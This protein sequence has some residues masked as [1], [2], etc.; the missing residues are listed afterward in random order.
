MKEWV[1]LS[2]VIGS[3]SGSRRS[4]AALL[5]SSIT[6]RSAS[7]LYAFVVKRLPFEVALP[8]GSYR[9]GTGA[10]FVSPVAAEIGKSP[11]VPLLVA[12]HGRSTDASAR[13][14]L[15]VGC[16]GWRNFVIVIIYRDE[17]RA[18]ESLTG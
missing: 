8:F 14:K 5:A 13:P 17:G 11:F 3:S 15:E 1:S 18:E 16:R 10:R 7:W 4:L 6:S 12:M 9:P 2:S